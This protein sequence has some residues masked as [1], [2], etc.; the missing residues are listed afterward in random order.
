MLITGTMLDFDGCIKKLS[1]SKVK[2]M[3][4]CDS[5]YLSLMITRLYRNR[6]FH[7]ISR[8]VTSVTRVNLGNEI[9]SNRK[10]R[11]GESRGSFVM[12]RY[13]GSELGLREKTATWYTQ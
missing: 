10:F 9:L 5:E 1:T 8:F 6:R 4:N 2:E 11:Q 3:Q 7:R 12:A 13:L